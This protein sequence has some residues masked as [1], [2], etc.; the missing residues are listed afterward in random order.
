MF[1]FDPK[2]AMFDITPVAN[3]FILEYLPAAKGDYVKVYLYGL[4]R[5]YHPEEEMN[6]DRMSHELGMTE[7]NVMNA[8]AYWERKRLVRRI[9]DNPPKWQYI[10]MI[11][12][13]LTE[14]RDDPDPGYTEFCN[15]LYE[16]FDKKRRLHG[17]ELSTC[18]EWREDLKLPTEVI[19]MLL[20]HMMEIK[21]KNF[22]ISDANKTALQM[23]ADEIRTVDAAEEFFSRDE[24]A[25]AGIKK[26]LKMLG[27]KYLPSEAQINLYRKWTR[28]WGF[29]HE[30]VEA[31][32]E[33]TAKG[34]PSLGYLDGILNSLQQEGSMTPEQIR[35]SSLRADGFKEILKELGKGDVSKRNLQLYDEMLS[36]YP[37]DVIL[38]AARECGYTGKDA[39][40]TL[41]L[42]LAWKDKGLENKDDVALYVKAFHDQTD[43]IRK[44]K[45]IWGTDEGRI[46]KADRSLIQKWLNEFGLSSDAVLAAAPYAAEAKQPM[47]YLDK[48]LGDC[49]DK[50]I[51]TPEEIRKEHSR[52]SDENRKK[53]SRVLPAQDFTQRPYDHVPDEMI[54]QLD[55]EVRAFMKENGGESDA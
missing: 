12:I 35:E 38:I 2:Y 50:G 16:A 26:I 11:Q 46:G 44:L 6:L 13:N 37:Q 8:F 21:G 20:N 55:D 27:K 4:M 15:A 9:S 48:I 49:R 43:L 1:G 23:A 31:A 10:N 18:F 28:D 33:L 53:P 47:A 36:L 3:Q 42:L 17:S 30:A 41:K 34:D 22:R 29:T 19:I 39:G 54:A 32:V 51:R 40:D 25:V 24:Q 45:K 14:D 52:R 5:C 7:E